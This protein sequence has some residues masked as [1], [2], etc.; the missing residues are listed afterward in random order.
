MNQKRKAG[1]IVQAC[2]LAIFWQCPFCEH[3]SEQRILGRETTGY[4]NLL[5][6]EHAHFDEEYSML[7][8][9]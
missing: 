5:K 9:Y 1:K 4:L 3:I 2:E 8:F 6:C 7:F